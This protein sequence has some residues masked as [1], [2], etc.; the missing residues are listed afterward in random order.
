MGFIVKIIGTFGFTGFFPFAPATFASLAFCAV[1]WYVPGGQWLVDPWVVL[2][3][4]IISIP[5]SSLL[6]KDYG[7]DPG[8]V[9][10]DEVAG[11]QLALV[12]SQDVSF[13]GLVAV[14]VLF[15]FFD[16]F[17]VFPADPAQKLPGGWGIVF[18]DLVAGIY[19]RIAVW[20]LAMWLPTFGVPYLGKFF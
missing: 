4:L 18:D 5:V 19:T 15:R 17:K 12:F 16:I 7:K 10:I 6:E 11:L 9:V 2:G 20:L 13:W 8:L 1:Y 3:T 14:F